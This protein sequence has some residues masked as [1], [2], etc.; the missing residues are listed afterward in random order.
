MKN[1]SKKRGNKLVS[2]INKLE[3]SNKETGEILNNGIEIVESIQK[4][5]RTKFY[6]DLFWK[7]E[8]KPELLSIEEIELAVK[9]SNNYTLKDIKEFNNFEKHYTGNKVKLKETLEH[10]TDPAFKCFSSLVVNYTSTEN[11]LQ[12]KNHVNIVKDINIAEVLNISVNKWQRI[13]KELINI[14]AIRKIKFQGKP[15]IKINPTIIGHSM[16]ITKCTYYAFRDVLID[17]FSKIKKIYWDKM[18]IEEFG[19]DI[20]ESSRTSTE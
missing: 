11:T 19:I 12:Y 16:K 3:F 15:I 8:N 1:K 18:L 7:F 2:K 9:V 4:E 14:S 13:K 5:E 17:E 10:L 6:R 20:I